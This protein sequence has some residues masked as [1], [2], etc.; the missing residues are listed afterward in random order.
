MGLLRQCGLNQVVESVRPFDQPLRM[1]TMTKW[2]NFRLVY[3]ALTVGLVVASP[4]GLAVMPPD[5]EA[6]SALQRMENSAQQRAQAS[7]VLLLRVLQV[8]SSR[9]Q[10]I[11]CPARE[12]WELEAEV[13]QVMRGQLQQG[14]TVH[15]RHVWQHF[16]CPGPIRE[17][18]PA[19]A[20]GMET[21]AFLACDE[22]GS[23][24]PAAD[25]MSFMSATEFTRVWGRRKQA[26]SE[27]A[28]LK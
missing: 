19:L 2:I 3:G 20:P 25:A 22:R 14:M 28:P 18:I 9:P 1:H 23:C 11:G 24:T 13:I 7:D 15:V 17:A 26:A 16:D 12:M 27:S 5:A 4:A 21:E 10:A 8:H 6:R